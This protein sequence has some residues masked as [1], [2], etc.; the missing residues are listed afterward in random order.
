[1]IAFLK[2]LR[3]YVRIRVWGFSPERF[4]NLCSNRNILL[5][6]IQKDGDVYEMYISLKGFFSLRPIVRK[7]G[8]RVAVLKRCGL[9]FF[10]P[11][12][13]A[14][15]FFVLGLM[16]AVIFWFWTS[17]YVWEISLSGNYSITEDVFHDFLKEQD[18]FVGMSKGK[19]DIEELEKQIRRQFDQVTWTSAKLE[20]TKLRIVIKE[21]ENLQYEVKEDT[22]KYIY[23]SDLVAQADGLIVSM[24]VRSGVPQVTIG[25]EILTGDVLVAGNV[26]V[27]NEDGTVRK[28]QYVRS[29]A[30]IYVQ[31][32]LSVREVLPIEYTDR[33][34]TGRT[35]S[36][37]YVGSGEKGLELSTKKV[38]YPY[39]D[40]LIE[41][42]DIQLLKGLTLPLFWGKITY[43]EYLNVEKRRGEEDAKKLLEIKY[44]EILSSLDEK[45][46]QIIEKDVK[47][48][49]DNIHWIL[50]GEFTVIQRIGIE[51]PGTVEQIVGTMMK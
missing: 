19:V 36:H 51:Q 34:Y 3:G 39:Y 24:I 49:R 25:Q 15:K 16:V 37:T 28:Y 38:T 11:K 8:T 42:K 50:E 29:D 21:N 30:D 17:L 12:V 47:I 43:R 20:G 27:N 6:D 35:T 23:G 45:G 33:V 32:K 44:S 41:K 46:V 26:P 1:M 9:P 4:M 2:Y 22:E 13:R 7:T 48:D 18:I 31:R 5:W 40:T 14:R 10:L